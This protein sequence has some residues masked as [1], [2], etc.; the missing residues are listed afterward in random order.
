MMPRE[1]VEIHLLIEDLPSRLSEERQEE[2]LGV[3]AK[4]AETE[5]QGETDGVNGMDNESMENEAADGIGAEEYAANGHG[6]GEED[7]EMTN[8]AHHSKNTEKDKNP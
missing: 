1:S 3:I 8:G 7:Y 6:N 2:L 5:G 4:Y